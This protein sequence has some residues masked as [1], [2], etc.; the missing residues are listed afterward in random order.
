MLRVVALRLI[1]RCTR[2]RAIA[3]LEGA[4]CTIECVF[5][6]LLTLE[7]AETRDV[8][9]QRGVGLGRTR[10]ARVRLCAVGEHTGILAGIDERWKRATGVCGERTIVERR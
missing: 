9:E 4:L 6:A 1:E 2:S 8:R 7:R 10:I 3:R 5:G